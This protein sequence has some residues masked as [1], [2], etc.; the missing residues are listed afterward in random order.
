MFYQQ[1]P[2]A[3][4]FPV[5]VNISACFALRPRFSLKITLKLRWRTSRPRTNYL[6]LWGSMANLRKPRNMPKGRARNPPRR[7][8]KFDHGGERMASGYG[9]LM[10]KRDGNGSR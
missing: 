4:V 9:A 3:R 1:I 2:F 7:P 10:E 6:V 8:S 5:P